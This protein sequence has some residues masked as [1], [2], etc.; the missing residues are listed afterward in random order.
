MTSTRMPG[1]P[2]ALVGVALI[3]ATAALMRAIGAID[4]L[5]LIL[6]TLGVSP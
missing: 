2:S 4:A 3:L 1:L 5:N 6:L